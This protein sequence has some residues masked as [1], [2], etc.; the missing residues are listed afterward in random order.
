MTITGLFHDGEPKC[1]ICRG[2]LLEGYRKDCG[3][4]ECPHARRPIRSGVYLPKKDW[5]PE[6]VE[7]GDG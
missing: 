4:S 3:L 7:E 6:F 5:I 1:A 2:S